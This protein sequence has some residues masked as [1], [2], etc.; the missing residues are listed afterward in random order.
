MALLEY[1]KSDQQ[2]QDEIRKFVSTFWPVEKQIRALGLRTQ[3]EMP[4]EVEK[5]I[6]RKLGERGWL[7]LGI[8]REYGGYGGT[9]LQRHLFTQMMSYYGVPYPRTAI[10]IVAP[11]MLLY[12]S[13]DMKARY[14]PGIAGGEFNMALGYSEPQAGS[15][16][17]KLAT[18]AI[19]DG[20]DYIITGQKVFTSRAERSHYCWLAARTDR[21]AEVHAGISLFVVDLHSPGVTIQPLPTISQR[22]NVT[23]YDEVRVA[24]RDM[25][26][27]E[28][29]GWTYLTGALGLERI[30]VF[31]MGRTRRLFEEVL[32]LAQEPRPDGVIPESSAE[33]R[34]R[35]A[36]FYVDLTGIESLVDAAVLEATRSGDV[37]PYAASMIKV[38]LTEFEQ[39]LADFAL[40]ML[41]IYGQLVEGADEAP[42]GG[43]IEHG[44]RDAFVG[45]IGG[46]TNAVQRDIIAK[47]GL[48]LPR[49]R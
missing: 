32:L 14:L 29:K 38:A 6:W 36:E 13:E 47:H 8:P 15:D 43:V 16:L 22:T 37:A 44:W 28:N 31:P 2:L 5:D 25:V 17:S 9:A 19:R 7:G 39:R 10:T 30:G 18:R 35:F 26:G 40:E 48:G 3:E 46:G 42:R 20:D 1:S 21:S 41:G 24:S 4:I 45:T 12:A 33:V 49:Y 27:D 23:Y 11:S 34:Q